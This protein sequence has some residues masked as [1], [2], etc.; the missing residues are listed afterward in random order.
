MFLPQDTAVSVENKFAE[1]M[2]TLILILTDCGE[3]LLKSAEKKTFSVRLTHA[4]VGIS[5]RTIPAGCETLRL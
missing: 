1:T 5:G 2:F 4:G 3:Q